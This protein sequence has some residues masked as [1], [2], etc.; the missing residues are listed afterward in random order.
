[1]PDL[2]IGADASRKVTIHCPVY[3]WYRAHL[4][5]NTCIGP[6]CQV[7]RPDERLANRRLTVRG[8]HF[9]RLGDASNMRQANKDA[10]MS[11]FIR[12]H[13]AIKIMK[14]PICHLLSLFHLFCWS[15][16]VDNPQGGHRRLV[17][18]ISLVCHWSTG[19][20]LCC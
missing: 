18:Y 4:V 15:L 16:C 19:S 11:K 10:M 7:H 3:A 13:D 8:P 2:N 20:Q 14:I 1:M 6:L 5:L 17:A 9:D 12:W